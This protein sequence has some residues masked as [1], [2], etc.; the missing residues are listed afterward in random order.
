MIRRD[1]NR[2]IL[3]GFLCTRNFLFLSL[4]LWFGM[5]PLKRLFCSIRLSLNLLSLSLRNNVLFH[6][7]RFHIIHNVSLGLTFPNRY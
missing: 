1:D 2:F 6:K 4:G 7:V 3:L 5:V